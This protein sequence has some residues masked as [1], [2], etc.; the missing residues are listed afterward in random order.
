MR[1]GQMKYPEWQAP[2]QEVILEF[3]HKKLCNKTQK[4]E[5]LILSG[6][7]SSAITTTVAASDRPST[8]LCLPYGSLSA[9][10]SVSPIGGKPR[11]EYRVPAASPI[12]DRRLEF[13][14]L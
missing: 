5:T 3:D 7:S 6:F 14:S 13:A 10:N 8:T 11:P 12:E 9:I 4:A 2:V 1:D